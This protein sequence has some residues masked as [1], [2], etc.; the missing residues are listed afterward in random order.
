MA[1]LGSLQRRRHLVVLSLYIALAVLWFWSTW[2]APA[3]TYV[4]NAGDPQA[5]MWYLRWVP[6]AI[7]HFK[8]PF[9]THYLGW[10]DGVNVMWNNANAVV[11]PAL[12][13]YPVTTIFGVVRSFNVMPRLAVA[14]SAFCAYLR[15]ARFVETTGGRPRRGLLFGFVPSFPP[16]ALLPFPPPISA[17]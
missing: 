12:L 16:H 9:F 6:Y 15:S 7:T 11:A 8:N 2:S 17:L 13:L 5:H 3:G 4:G 1:R 14:L 10:P